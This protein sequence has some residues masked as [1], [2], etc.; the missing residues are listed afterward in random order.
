MAASLRV[1]L[2]MTLEAKSSPDAMMTAPYLVGRQPELMLESPS[3]PTE[4]RP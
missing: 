4:Y 3:P 2:V 1:I